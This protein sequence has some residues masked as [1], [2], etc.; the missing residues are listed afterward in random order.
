M[1]IDKI[2]PA[3]GENKNNLIH[4]AIDSKGVKP[5]KETDE[6]KDEDWINTY[7]KKLDELIDYFIKVDS[8]VISINLEDDKEFYNKLI[9]YFKQLLTDQRI[10]TN[11]IRIFI[12][13]QW[14]G[15]NNELSEVIKELME[16]TK[17]YDNHFLGFYINYDG[18]EEIISSLKIVLRKIL[19]NKL[20]EEELN[21][22]VIKENLYSSYFP[23]P[24]ILINTKNTNNGLL[25]WDSYNAKLYVSEKSFLLIEKKDL[26]EAIEIVKQE[27]RQL[28]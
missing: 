20:R 4:I 8:K 19:S 10:T 18:K 23:P 5:N 14:Y 24:D 16:K 2:I 9:V 21:Q 25:L 28:K 17:D 13:G 12:L 11:K 22:E 1:V 6:K 27:K 3:L 15:L 7:I 26:D